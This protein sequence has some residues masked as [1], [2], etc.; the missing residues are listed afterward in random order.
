MGSG[1]RKK[2]TKYV[3]PSIGGGLAFLCPALVPLLVRAVVAIAP[4][5]QHPVRLTR[6]GGV[7]VG[8]GTTV[9][10]IEGEEPLRQALNAGCR[11][12]I[13]VVEPLAPGQSL[14]ADAVLE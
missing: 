2:N 10:I 5:S 4:E 8:S 6:D 12:R 3:A 14:L 11:Y 1:N 7:L 9:Q 13:V